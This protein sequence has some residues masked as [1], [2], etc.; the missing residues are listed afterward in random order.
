MALDL[1]S[2]ADRLRDRLDTAVWL[3]PSL[4]LLGA[5]ALSFAAEALGAALPGADTAWYLFRGGPEGARTLL[6]VVAS[7]MMVLTGVVFSVTILVLQLASNQF[8]PR[9]LRHFLRDRRA[10]TVLGVF[11]STFLYCLLG[12]RSVRGA[13]DAIESHVP[14]LTVWVAV[15][16]GAGCIG[17]LVYFLHHVAQSIRAVNVLAAIGDDGRHHLNRLYPEGLGEE[18]EAPELDPPDGV[19]SLVVP[20]P[21]TSGVLL[22]VDEERLWS[23]AGEAHVTVALL[24]MV[25]DFVVHHRPVFEVWGDPSELDVES[26]LEALIVA[27]ERNSRQDLAFSFRELVDVAERALSPGVNDPT[28]AVQAIDQLHDLLRRLVHRRFPAAHRVDARGRLRLILPRPSWDAYVRL[29]VD[30]I[31]QSGGGM[32]QVARR[33]RFL[34]DDLLSVAPPSRCGELRRQLALLQASVQREFAEPLERE[35]AH[36]ASAQG[37][38]PN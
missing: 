27:R 22:S 3:I 1:K 6:S 24:P 21:G 5:V 17:A 16:L 20:F 9:V 30:E 15:V 36:H 11:V 2:I 14:A 13:T 37:H 32:L 25:G 35:L 38:G 28:T 18:P 8:S 4:C 26:M 19:P 31:R 12:L 34:L 10:Q 33:L 23:M 29:A 7:A